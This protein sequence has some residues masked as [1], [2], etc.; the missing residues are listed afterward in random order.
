MLLKIIAKLL[1][2]NGFFRSGLVVLSVVL[3]L[4]A[5]NTSAVLA[6]SV[7]LQDIRVSGTSEQVRLVLDLSAKPS[8][9]IFPL[10]D[11]ARLVIDLHDV[12]LGENV[13]D[14]STSNSLVSAY[15]V[16]E[17]APG[18]VRIVLGLA[19]PGLAQNAFL[20]PAVGTQPA[21][22]VFELEQVSEVVFV[23][24]YRQDRVNLPEIDAAESARNAVLPIPVIPADVVA[25]AQVARQIILIDPGHGGIDGGAVTRNG[26]REKDIVFEF[27]GLLEDKLIATGKFDVALTREEDVFVGL[28]K[29]VE[30]ARQNKVDLLIS[31]HADSFTQA[32]VGG[33]S[34]YTLAENATDI[35]DKV[36]ADQENK[37]DLVA[38]FE[39]PQDKSE[40]VDILVDLMRRETRQRSYGIGRSIM[41]MFEG[42]VKLRKFPLRQADFFVLQAPEV[43]SILIELG[44]LSN[45]EDARNMASAAWRET[46]STAIV[47]GVTNFMAPD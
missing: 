22:M 37:A 47:A 35:L 20:L 34:I 15:S 4:F 44:F 32:S 27:A 14:Q 39:L 23:R 12:A 45:A 17:I 5:G 46:A 9:T 6:Q 10:I 24:Q 30:L 13:P 31:L 43:P 1:N 42:R 40:V 18:Q 21:R 16:A 3:A 19:S 25:S 33:M 29:R 41:D 28:K 26:L 38:G 8:F 2:E 7:R 36:L 11:P